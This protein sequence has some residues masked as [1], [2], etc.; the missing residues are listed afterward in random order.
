MKLGQMLPSAAGAAATANIAIT[1]KTVVNTKAAAKAT[2]ADNDHSLTFAA[3][4]YQAGNSTDFILTSTSF[5]INGVDH[6]FGD[7]PIDGSAERKI[8]IYKVEDDVNITVENDVGRIDVSK[9][10]LNVKGFSIDTD[11]AITLTL[12]PNSLDIAPKRNQLLTIDPAKVSVTP[13]VDTITTKGSSGS[14]DYTVNSRL[15]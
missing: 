12:T 9:G 11:T 3:P 10:T 6:F 2:A 5:K 14:I 7:V 4:F 1:V 8:I 15:R 13:Q